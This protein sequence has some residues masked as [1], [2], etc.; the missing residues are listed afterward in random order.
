M[1]YGP[2]CHEEMETTKLS[3]AH[4]HTEFPGDVDAGLRTT[5]RK[6]LLW[7]QPHPS[8]YL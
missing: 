2:Y 6:P 1:G 8:P 4:M 7:A 3:L 5:L